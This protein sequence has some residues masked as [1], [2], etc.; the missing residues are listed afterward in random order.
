MKYIFY[1]V[2][3]VLFIFVQFSFLPYSGVL[4]YLSLPLCFLIIYFFSRGK[5]LWFYFLI[6]AL[7]FDLYSI[8][9]HGL[10]LIIF[11]IFYIFL[12]WVQ[13]LVADVGSFL[14]LL[15]IFVILL[16][17]QLLNLIFIALAYYLKLII[18]SVDLNKA[19][20]FQTL[21]LIIINTVI[22]FLFNKLCLTRLK[23]K[24]LI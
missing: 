13:K 14:K 10:Y 5:Y 9:P 24:R 2:I 22:I 20:I 1:F 7:L 19:Y 8:L 15:S 23:Q 11:L 3:L 18:F 4:H 12:T 21:L 6:T 16:F 17:Y